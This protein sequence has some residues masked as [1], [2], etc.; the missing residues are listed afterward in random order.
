MRRVI[1]HREFSAPFAK[2]KYNDGYDKPNKVASPEEFFPYVFTSHVLSLNGCFDLGHF[3]SDFRRITGFL[4]KVSEIR[5]GLLYS[6]VVIAI[7]INLLKNSVKI[8]Y[9]DCKQPYEHQTGRD[10]LQSKWHPPNVLAIRQAQSNT[11]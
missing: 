3:T 8:E 6:S 5:D 7:F 10:K 1:A 2:K 11:D 4:S 9:L